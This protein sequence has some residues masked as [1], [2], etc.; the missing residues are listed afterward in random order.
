M[1]ERIIGSPALRHFNTL[2]HQILNE[3]IYIKQEL[4]YPV[5]ASE[6]FVGKLHI[7]RTL[8]FEVR[9]LIGCGVDTFFFS[10][11][12]KRALVFVLRTSQ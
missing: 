8:S 6:S 12:T 3:K 5:A 4:T 1:R 10:V 11:T 2:Y 9:S 7:R